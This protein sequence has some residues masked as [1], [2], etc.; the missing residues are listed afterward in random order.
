MGKVA[1]KRARLRPRIVEM[2][3]E[4]FTLAD[5]GEAVGVSAP[6]VASYLRWYGIKGNPQTR[7]TPEQAEK[8]R[9]CHDLHDLHGWTVEQLRDELDEPKSTIMSWLRQSRSEH[10]S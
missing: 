4:G 3:S 10:W 2:R 5:I 7:T 8:R 1:D 6:T 9:R